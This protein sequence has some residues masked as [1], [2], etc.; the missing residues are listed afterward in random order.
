MFSVGR[1]LLV[2][3]EFVVNYVLSI[4]F[5]CYVIALCVIPLMFQGSSGWLAFTYLARSIGICY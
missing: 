2:V 5:E 3:V 4:L 1:F